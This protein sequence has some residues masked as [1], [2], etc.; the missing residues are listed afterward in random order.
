MAPRQHDS[1]GAAALADTS[2][3]GSPFDPAAIIRTT[4]SLIDVI[5]EHYR[6]LFLI[7]PLYALVTHGI[8]A[9][10]LTSAL[11][12]AVVVYT[13]TLTAAER[14][15]PDWIASR[16]LQLRCI[17]IGLICIGLSLLYL[18]TD[19]LETLY[20]D[21]FYA[22]FV[23][24]AGISAGRRGVLWS[25]TLAAVAVAIGQVVVASEIPVIFT[26]L[27]LEFWIVV[28]LYSGT[29]GLFFMAIGL[30]ANLASDF[31]SQHIA[32][33]TAAGRTQVAD[34]QTSSYVPGIERL[35]EVTAHRERLATMG[36]ITAQ[37]IHG[38]SS[39]LTG[40]ST[41]ADYLLET[42]DEQERDSVEMLK[43]EAARA[44]TLVRELLN[45]AR[46]DGKK[47][48]VSLNEIVESALRLSALRV[49]YRRTELLTELSDEIT[50][51]EASRTQIEQ[52]IFNLLDNAH[53]ALDGRKGGRI[54][55][56]TKVEDGHVILEIEDNGPG[57]PPELKD[58]VFEPFFTT[59][60][61]GV[62]TGLG[63]AIVNGIV[64]ECGG[65]ISL[66]SRAGHTSFSIS[67]PH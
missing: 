2:A 65:T 46:R 19:S 14:R 11:A 60:D 13:T 1:D 57:V 53:Q 34:D 52:V 7:I 58:R 9:W 56:R 47:G 35:L 42:V 41:L 32:S 22:I 24:L 48:N 15:W 8:A 18:Y 33:A 25:A 17:E 29:F 64:R 49:R 51:I 50:A 39:P 30:L 16:G 61:P 43:A 10:P 23:A 21:G 63:L 3:A 26:R 54:T 31:E 66:A 12:A 38:L 67:F 44:S 5:T 45:F 6:W 27:G 40:I 28:V 20:Y 59:K 36:Q 55:I 62:G 4:R 37:V